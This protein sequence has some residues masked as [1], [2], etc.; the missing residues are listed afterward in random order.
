MSDKNKPEE[1]KAL[2]PIL[3]ETVVTDSPIANPADQGAWNKT[4]EAHQLKD[5]DSATHIGLPPGELQKLQAQ[6]KAE[7]FEIFDP[8]KEAKLGPL[9]NITIDGTVSDQ[10]LK[11]LRAGIKEIPENERRFLEK[12]GVKI[13]AKDIVNGHAGSPAIYE[14]GSKK[15]VVGMAGFLEG[16][17]SPTETNQT[18]FKLSTKNSDVAG[19]FK[20]EVGHA[21]FDTL[22]IEQLQELKAVIAEE[23]AKVRNDDKEALAHLLEE[24]D[25]IFAESYAFIRGRESPRVNALIMNFP[26][27]IALI[28]DILRTNKDLNPQ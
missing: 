11:Q 6:G 19:S 5:G 23:K 21:I 22:K 12:A 14:P 20:H 2:E 16:G 8:A 24:D 7:K 18:S 13:V 9:E 26:R 25:E 1:L 27:T 15:V 10:F 28:D 4:Q 17:D 3:D